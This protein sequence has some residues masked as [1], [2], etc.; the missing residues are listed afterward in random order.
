MSSSIR[1]DGPPDSRPVDA[2]PSEIEIREW[3]VA[4]LADLLGLDERAIDPADP[5]ASYGLDSSGA[6]GMAGDVSAWLGRDLDAEL[7]YS[8]PTIDALSR[9]LAGAAA[10]GSPV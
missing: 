1:D 9:Y 8:Y 10:D 3:L 6:V 2:A 5:L 7:V 4:Y